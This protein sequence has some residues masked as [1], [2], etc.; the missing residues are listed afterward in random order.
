MLVQRMGFVAPCTLSIILYITS[1]PSHSFDS[2][3][4]AR[5]PLY[6]LHITIS[7]QVE[8]RLKSV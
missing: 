6:G 7:V 4:R 1:T 3:N 5:V 2:R 8:K